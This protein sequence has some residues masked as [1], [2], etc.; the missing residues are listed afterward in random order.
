MGHPHGPGPGP[1]GPA[2]GGPPP[3][4]YPHGP[5]PGPGGPGFP[6]H[7]GPGMP[8][9][10]RKSSNTGLLIGLLAG[11]GFLVMVIVIVILVASGVF[12]SGGKSPAG[13]DSG[14][15]PT[16]KLA[17]AAQRLSGIPGIGLK[18]TLSSG[19]DK[20]EGD[21]K[22][23]R[24]GRM[25]GTATWNGR[26]VRLILPGE[27]MYV[28]AGPEFWRTDGNVSASL[29]WLNDSRWGKLG[30]SS[31]ATAFKNDISP[32]A[33]AKD[34]RNVTRYSVRS[35]EDTAV[36]GTSAL[37]IV[38]AGGTYYVSAD[39]S[40]RLLR[41]ET[42]YPAA[43]MDVTELNGPGG[44]EAVTELR[45]RINELKNS[46][47]PD[48][49]TRVEKI[50]WGSCTTSGCTVHSTVWAGR[51]SAPSISVT[52]FVRLNAENKS[53]RKLG[54]C[55]GT[56][57]IR[58]FDSISVTCRVKSA[59]WSKFRGGSGYHRWWG[60]AEAMAGGASSEDVQKM[61]SALTT[62]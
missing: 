54:E 42:A 52:V 26:N 25:S 59:A 6:P 45:T 50:K 14:D 32:S 21:F 40:P 7:A 62:E 51:G 41:V 56:G 58:S 3:M 1:G 15:S 38:T 16:G 29:Q 48:R 10:P 27:D 34:L 20:L 43:A 12:S 30:Y 44:G 47:A 61:L 19:S 35:T 2:Q 28:R 31:L 36:Q 39:G 13:G 37:K 53:G 57:V 24:G 60:H 55:T 46:F 9:P 33:L 5:G 17:A 22:V 23:T 4:G 11:G 49:T 8:P 18:G